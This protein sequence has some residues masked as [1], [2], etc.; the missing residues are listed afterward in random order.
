MI[1]IHMLVKI[2]MVGP[3]GKPTQQ[4]SKVPKR[5]P[6]LPAAVLLSVQ[7][8]LW[9]QTMRS[10]RSR[11]LLSGATGTRS[12]PGKPARWAERW[13]EALKVAHGTD[14]PKRDKAKT[15]ERA[16]FVMNSFLHV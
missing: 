3:I 6:D 13:V 5:H 1:I 12:G 4:I 14:N 8:D 10:S 15:L 9:V 2:K 16:K 11:S 7:D